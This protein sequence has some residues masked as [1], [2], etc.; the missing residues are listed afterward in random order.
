MKK[1]LISSP[2]LTSLIILAVP[3]YSI[4]QNSSAD[5]DEMMKQRIELSKTGKNHELLASITGKWTFV[6]R[7]FS[8][9]PN[10]KPFEFKAKAERKAVMDGRYFIVETTGGKLVMPWSDGKEVTYIDIS[11]EGYD[12]VKKKF[13]IAMMAN[14]WNTG[15]ALS[16]GTYDS[17]S[18]TIAY[19]SGTTSPPG[20]DAMTRT[21]LK[22][23]D[24]DHYNLE[25]YRFINGR[26][27]KATEVN[28]TR[29]KDFATPGTLHKML[30]R[31]NGK[32]TG[33]VTLQFSADAAPVSGGT[34]I[35]TNSMA[36]DG[37]YQVSEIKGNITKVMGDSWTGI[38]ITG[39][40]SARKVFTRAMIGDG[41]SSGGVGMEGPWNETKRSITM[42]FKKT[43]P[44]TGKVRDL[45][46]VYKIVDENTE[47]LE[48]YAI[49]EKTGKEFKMLNVTWKREK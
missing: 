3:L 15:F 38:R 32:W 29:E 13:I 1:Y 21:L 6:G 28:Y 23:I 2:V 33:E 30:A 5:K 46:E 10:Q 39:Y 20:I 25:V 19:T 36:M 49:D 47:V 9:D 48:I 31:S 8:P 45:K 34:S 24:R 42:P 43:D 12:N 14:H 18:R 44:A 37:L 17:A 11:I 7:H 16:E 40:D 4:A 41:A 27:I 35:L 22:I 26:E